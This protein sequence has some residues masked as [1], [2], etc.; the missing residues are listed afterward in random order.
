MIP[1]G[2][3]F[4]HIGLF[5]LLESEA[6]LASIL[7]HELAHYHLKHSVTQYVE[8]AHYHLKHSVTQ[9]VKEEQGKFKPGFFMKNQYA[10]K[11]F[12]IESELDADSLS[13]IWMTDAGYNLK[14]MIQSFER[15][16]QVG[17]QKK[18]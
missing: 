7:A 9:Y 6:T 16:E 1:S 8:L 18:D 13:M 17:V 14:G 11:N 4:V 10:R 5:D 3:M 2:M 12:S 15:T